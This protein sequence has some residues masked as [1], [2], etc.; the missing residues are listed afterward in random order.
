VARSES[1]EGVVMTIREAAKMLEERIARHREA[2]RCRY[3]A[4]C[5]CK[6]CAADR[7]Y[8][9]LSDIIDVCPIGMPG[10]WRGAGASGQR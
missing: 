5:P 1:E 9:A 7:Y 3:D 8:D 2:T 4:S 6:E 10:S